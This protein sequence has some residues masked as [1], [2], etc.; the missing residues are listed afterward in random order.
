M[1][2]DAPP[3]PGRAPTPW[4]ARAL[5]GAPL[6]LGLCLALPA[7]R[8]AQW[9]GDTGLYAAISAKVWRDGC[10]FP[11]RGSMDPYFNKPPLAFW[12]HALSMGLFGDGTLGLYLPEILSY[13][14][15]I[16]LTQY[17]AFRLV[18]AADAGRF[19]GAREGTPHAR[20]VI[21]GAIAGLLLASTG[22]FLSIIDT[23]K[24]DYPHNAL[25]FASVAMMCAGWTRTPGSED[26]R[27]A[28]RARRLVVL[29][30]VPMGLALLVKPMWGL[31]SY[32]PVLAWV[33]LD[34]PGGLA[35]R[36]VIR[37]M[38]SSLGLA[39]LVALPWH[40]AMALKTIPVVPG[41]GAPAG[42]VTEY[43]G[44]QSFQ[45]VSRGLIRQPWWW[46]LNYLWDTCRPLVLSAAAGL[47][48]SLLYVVWRK[49]SD[50]PASAQMPEGGAGGSRWWRPR[51]P[52]LF[53]MLW[54]VFW[55]A[56]LSC[57]PDKRRNYSLHVLPM[58]AVLV[59]LLATWPLAAL[60]AEGARSAAR[61]GALRR[62]G[63]LGGLCAVAAT[64]AWSLPSPTRRFGAGAER[65]ERVYQDKWGPVVEF[66]K[67]LDEPL[68]VG[69]I[70]YADAGMLYVKTGRWALG[71]GW[72]N[73]PLGKGVPDGAL[74]IYDEAR[75]APSPQ[76]PVV[77]RAAPHAG[78]K[79]VVIVRR[80]P[81]APA[82]PE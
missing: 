22:Q 16:V 1:H 8:V 70:Y 50:G 60:A 57:V 67:T 65:N 54:C 39:L 69:S 82:D 52:L 78:G 20:A 74:V 25:L 58:L 55:L 36:R 81:G 35:R 43:F 18:R 76:A 77:F 13:L 26:P 27:S 75:R 72:S 33:L 64:L 46:Y 2:P 29:A 71:R 45:R 15:T 34:P 4:W 59:A 9:S 79:G 37:W 48:T 62:L 73:T 66:V 53:A 32:V 41:P 3:N 47:A 49:R 44:K 51:G 80:T 10:W 28:A 42:F 17:I 61:V 6:A 14:A 56:V 19:G 23:L 24:L 68:Y 40:L 5:T 63:V 21:V 12:L 11:L 7:L 30:G 31:A 38:L